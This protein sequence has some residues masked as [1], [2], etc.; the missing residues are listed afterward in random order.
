[1]SNM[2][3]RVVMAIIV[4]TLGASCKEEDTTVSG[5]WRRA[6][7]PWLTGM[8]YDGNV[9]A[10]V[11]PPGQCPTAVRTQKDALRVLTT[12]L[13]CIDDAIETLKRFT[14]TDAYTF[15]DLAGAHY[16]RA[17]THDQPRDYLLALDLADEAVRRSPRHPAAHFNRALIQEAM[18]LYDEALSSY[19]S[20][21]AASPWTIEARRR[22]DNLHRKLSSNAIDQ[23]RQQIQPQL[24]AALRARNAVAVKKIV[25]NYPAAAQRHFEMVVLPRWAESGAEEE[26]TQA[27]F[28][29]AEL[30]ARLEDPY[31]NDTID[32]IREG[33]TNDLRSGHLKFAEAR[34]LELAFKISADAFSVA[35]RALAGARS[36]FR[37][38]ARLGHITA[39]RNRP[40]LDALERDVRTAGYTTFLPRITWIRAWIM[41]ME[42]DLLD[43]LEQYDEAQKQY[44]HLRDVEG[45]LSVRMRHAGVLTA[46]G[47]ADLAWQE[48]LSVFQQQRLIGMPKE[49]QTLV[50]ESARAVSALGHSDV[51]LHYRQFAVDYARRE[52]QQTSP[53]DTMALKHV[54]A[55]LS[56]ALQNL[57]EA[58]I[59]LDRSAEATAHLIDATRLY[60]AEEPDFRLRDDAR[61]AEIQG[62]RLLE[63]SPALAVDQFSRA[64]RLAPPKWRNDLAHLY[65]QRAEAYRKLGDRKAA[66]ED[67]RRTVG[68]LNTEEQQIVHD[69]RGAGEPI[70][71]GYFSRFEATYALLIRHY[72]DEGEPHTAFQ[73]AERARG[74]EPLQRIL[75]LPH[76]PADFRRIG[77]LPRIENIQAR[78]RPGTYILEY[79]VLDDE[80]LTWVIWH[81][82]MRLVRQPATRADVERWTRELQDAVVERA[83]REFEKNLIAPYKGL[84]A[85][86]LSVVREQHGNGV[87]R[88]VVVPDRV[89][90]GL[91]F[92][93]FRES[94]KGRFLIEQAVLEVHGSALLYVFS[95]MRDQEMPR[96][97]STLL[98]GNPAFEKHLSVARDMTS[99]TFAEQEVRDIHA[100]HPDE[101]ELL[102]GEKATI[103]K[104]LELARHKAIV[105][106]AAHAVVNAEAPFKS[107]LLM[108]PT[109]GV[110]DGTLEAQELLRRAK[111]DRTRLVILAACSSVGGA[112]VGPE[113]VGPLVRPIVTAGVPAVLGTLWNVHDATAQEVLVSFHRH[114]QKPGS[115]AA[116]AL[117]EAQLALLGKREAMTWAP[118]QV[119]GHATSPY[120]ATAKKEE[121]P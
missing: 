1:M 70:W 49:F 23:W 121:P 20:L 118:Y 120:G 27:A 89:M 66:L 47:R 29:A 96:D 50:G 95:S 39:S 102:T 93:A 45:E 46:L 79:S 38:A 61:F 22:A 14:G 75:R 83:A 84:V 12:D 60:R 106:L 73:Y 88:L 30:S 109:K 107:V 111:L 103:G 51:A 68:V 36:P 54:E 110:D 78:L 86:A 87:P 69:D 24:D 119:I 18:G 48:L 53:A 11:R 108:A 115:D 58:A 17:K 99:L 8:I 3:L 28:L 15:S 42:S 21:T 97:P 25:Q 92:A 35:E 13:R 116:V 26:L 57:A 37:F 74:F 40:A 56:T 5:R 9:P 101:S 67:L 55:R 114:F 90:Q 98:V 10:P 82:G 59:E 52:L 7:E 100:L 2:K 117:R 62:Q 43:A 32:A 64:I 105:H 85:K 76:T 31:F 81:D 94:S 77:T 63:R 104:F 4:C 91:P 34:R 6:V 33:P 113:G 72:V 44:Q 41:S 65:A 80:T 112:P 19:R 16:L 71:S